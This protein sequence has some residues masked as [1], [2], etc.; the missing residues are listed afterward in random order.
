MGGCQLLARAVGRALAADMIL[1]GRRL[2]AAEALA[3]GLVSRVVPA[4]ALLEET[5]AVARAIGAAPLPVAAK[6]KAAVAAAA[7]SHLS[8][9]IA[10]ERSEF[11]ACFA[12]RD[13]KEGMRAFVEKRPPAFADE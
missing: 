6:A 13:Q 1:T 10:A 11:W 8:A 2:S 7:E 12:L 5:G 4:S 3:A 9:G